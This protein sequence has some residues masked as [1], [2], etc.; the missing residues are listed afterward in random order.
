MEFSE[1]RWLGEFEGEPFV[2]PD[3]L[4][5]GY[6]EWRASNGTLYEA[7]YPRGKVRGE[8]EH[9]TGVEDTEEYYV[10]NIILMDGSY[11]HVDAR[12]G[13]LLSIF[14]S[15]V[16]GVLTF[17]TAVRVVYAP[18]KRVEEWRVQEYK[19][20]GDFESEP[21]ETPDG[22]VKGHLLWRASNGTLYEVWLPHT[23][24]TITKVLYIEA[25]DDTEEYN[26]WEITTENNVY[27]IDAR[28]GIIRLILGGTGVS[29]I[30]P[31]KPLP[32]FVVHYL[33]VTLEEGWSTVHIHRGSLTTITIAVDRVREDVAEFAPLIYVSSEMFMCGRDEVK[34]VDR[35]N[36]CVDGMTINLN[37]SNIVFSGIEKRAYAKLTINV[38]QDVNPATYWFEI[39]VPLKEG[40]G[41]GL[42]SLR[43]VV[44]G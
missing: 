34:L 41:F 37:P 26:I 35:I 21:Y 31:P 43:I 36:S 39:L 32:S 4:V 9:F 8:V 13:E 42:H 5:A 18:Q 29:P 7:E 10:W 1:Y 24:Y 12:N 44:E 23:R 40:K 28:N 30:P 6:L 15:R 22:L 2:T 3:G 25:P 20:I 27:Y 14:P 11:R 17:E 33:N 38:S 19:R 16:P